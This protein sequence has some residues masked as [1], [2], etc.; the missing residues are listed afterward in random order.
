MMITLIEIFNSKI[1]INVLL[2]LESHPDIKVREISRKI[3]ARYTITREI[4]SLEEHGLLE[5]DKDSSH[6]RIRLTQKGINFLKIYRNTLKKLEK[7]S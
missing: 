6:Y 4:Q 5:I 2:T 7:L 3:G 1:R